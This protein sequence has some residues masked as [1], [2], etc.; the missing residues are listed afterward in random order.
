MR[1]YRTGQIGVASALLA[2]ALFGPAHRWPNLLLAQIEPW[3][4]AALLY[5]GSVSASTSR[6]R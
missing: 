5:L 3:L 1:V 4:L 2:A 6:V